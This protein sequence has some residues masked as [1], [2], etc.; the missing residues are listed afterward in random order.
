MVANP[1]PATNEYESADDDDTSAGARKGKTGGVARKTAP[2]LSPAEQA[3][4]LRAVITKTKVRIMAASAKVKLIEAQQAKAEADLFRITAGEG[5]E[6][7]ENSA[8]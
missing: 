5:E 1:K 3:T 4:K 6:M 2:A 8:A 7:E